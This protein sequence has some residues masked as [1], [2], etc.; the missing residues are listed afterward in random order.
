MNIDTWKSK[1]KLDQMMVYM[2][3]VQLVSNTDHTIMFIS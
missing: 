3:G 1:N 2:S